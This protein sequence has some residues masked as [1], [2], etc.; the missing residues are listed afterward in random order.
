ML[1]TK[2]TVESHAY[3]KEINKY[4]PQAEV[5]EMAAPK[6]VP[7]IESGCNYHELKKAVQEYCIKDID[8]WVLGCTHFPYIRPILEIDYD[9]YG[10]RK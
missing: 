7:I 4:C 2:K 9:L 6:L 3:L 1:A 8:A 5:F 10:C